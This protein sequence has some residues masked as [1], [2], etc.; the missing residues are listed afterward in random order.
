MTDVGKTRCRDLIRLNVIRLRHDRGWS[1]HQLAVEA[2]ITRTYL[3]YVESEGRNV[4]ADVICSLSDAL[5]VDPRDLLKPQE[6][7]PD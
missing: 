7:W 4:S 1:Q 3:S 6:E 5:D 2:G